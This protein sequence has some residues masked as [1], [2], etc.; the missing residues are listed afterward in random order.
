M[1]ALGVDLMAENSPQTAPSHSQEFLDLKLATHL[2]AWIP[3]RKS[4]DSKAFYPLERASAS[5]S[6]QPVGK[7]SDQGCVT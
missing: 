2:G 4:A 6:G 3:F 1:A 7:E 5:V